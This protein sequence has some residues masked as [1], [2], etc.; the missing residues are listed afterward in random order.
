MLKKPIRM[1]KTLI[2][3]NFNR[4]LI[5]DFFIQIL[6]EANEIKNLQELHIK[7]TPLITE[8]GLKHIIESAK[9]Y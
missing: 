7:H 3:L 2:Y 1:P 8:I 4:T 9:F 6:F 5:N